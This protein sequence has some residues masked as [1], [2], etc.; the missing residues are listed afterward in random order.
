MKWASKFSVFAMGL[1]VA[2]ATHPAAAMPVLKIAGST[3]VCVDA[4]VVA[5]LDSTLLGCRFNQINIVP[6]I[7]AA[8]ADESNESVAMLQEAEAAEEMIA[9]LIGLQVNG[10][11][12]VALNE[13]EL[14]AAIASLLGEEAGFSDAVAEL[15]TTDATDGVTSD[16]TALISTSGGGAFYGGSNACMGGK[17]I[18][19]GGHANHYSNHSRGIVK[20]HIVYPAPAPGFNGEIISGATTPLPP[21]ALAGMVLI[22]ALGTA[23]KV[24]STRKVLA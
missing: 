20:P 16:T 17:A 7:E 9:S 6:S 13:A 23:H 10:L 2:T 24:R 21:G 22:G 8:D 15:G 4:P 12:G 1:A 5:G 19:A 11:E 14:D 18:I 3:P